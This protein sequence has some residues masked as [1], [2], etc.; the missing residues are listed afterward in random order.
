MQSVWV[1]DA[2]RKNEVLLSKQRDRSRYF[3]SKMHII[4]KVDI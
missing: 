1:P 4:M 3:L 2:G